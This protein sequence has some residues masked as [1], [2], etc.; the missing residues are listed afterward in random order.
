MNRESVLQTLIQI[1]GGFCIDDTLLRELWDLVA[2]TGVERQ[3]FSLLVARL[4]M[5]SAAG[6]QATQY[7]EFEPLGGGL[8]SMHLARKEF[9][10]RILYGF[11]HDKEP[12]LLLAFYERGGKRKTD[13]TPYIEPAA[14][15]LVAKKEEHM[16]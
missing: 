14:A 7:R 12:V 4:H 1:L 2:G 11:L 5:L 3:F 15:R 8:F 13:Y 16:A 6:L 9:N 10:I